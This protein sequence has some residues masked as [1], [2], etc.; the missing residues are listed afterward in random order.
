MRQNRRIGTKTRSD[1]DAQDDSDRALG[2][3][4]APPASRSSARHR[5]G[6]GVHLCTKCSIVANWTTRRARAS[7]RGGSARSVASRS[8]L[9]RSESMRSGCWRVQRWSESGVA[10]SV[11]RELPV[12]WF[13][14]ASDTYVE[15]FVDLAF[16][17]EDGWV[18]VDY[19][20][21][22][23][24]GKT[25][26]LL[27]RYRPQLNAYRS[28]LSAAGVAVKDAGLWFSETGELHAS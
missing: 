1:R 21:D 27:S 19:K 18:I 7:G 9:T 3:R 10:K 13:E 12:A 26:T 25:T 23:V 28:A 6:S 16:E 5:H 8:S 15:G 4:R 22:R 24:A 20:T 14:E 2:A 11:L 17:E